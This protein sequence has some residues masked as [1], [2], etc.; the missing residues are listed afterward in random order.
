MPLAPKFGQRAL[1]PR[2]ALREAKEIASSRAS[3]PSG[4]SL[5]LDGEAPPWRRRAP[6]RPLSLLLES[7]IG[8]RHIRTDSL[9]PSRFAAATPAGLSPPENAAGCSVQTQSP[10]GP[11]HKHAY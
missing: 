10:A 11:F 3:A 9:L 6:P 2:R 8:K 4:R 1:T 5:R 7:M